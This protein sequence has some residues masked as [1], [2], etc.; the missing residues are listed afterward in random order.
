MPLFAK[1]RPSKLAWGELQR[2]SDPELIAQVCSGNGDALAVIVDRYRRL[3][4]S[5]AFRI[6]KNECE[7]EDV[8]QGV[9]IEIYR[10][11]AQFDP[12]RG[13]LKMWLLQFTYSRS[14]NRRQYLEQREFY[15][16]AGLDEVAPF[17]TAVS[18]LRLHGLSSDET[19]LVVRRALGSLNNDQQ[20]AIELVYFQG[21][22]LKEAAEKTGETLAAVRHHYYRGLIRMRAFIS[23]E[24]SAYAAPSLAEADLGLEVANLKP[25]PV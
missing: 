8:T 18:S 14:I 20:T 10:K 12:A 25:R 2:A 16:Q 19:G 11:A 6:V 1:S 24:G 9:F 23:A 15:T 3:V 21:L 7:A 5:V 4:F 17:Q 22:T 13:T